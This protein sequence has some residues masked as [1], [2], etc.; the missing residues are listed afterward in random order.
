MFYLKQIA[1]PTVLY[2]PVT[3]NYFVAS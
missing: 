3:K 1:V 2:F